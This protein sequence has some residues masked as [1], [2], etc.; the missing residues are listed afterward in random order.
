MAGSDK[1][2]GHEHCRGN[3]GDAG[4]RDSDAAQA[5]DEFGEYPQVLFR[6]P[7]IDGMR[8]LSA[9]RDR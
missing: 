4:Q 1:L 7:T 5:G 2:E 3:P 8:L 6:L 9:G